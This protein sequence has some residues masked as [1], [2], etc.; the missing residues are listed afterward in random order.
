MFALHQGLNVWSPTDYSGFS[1]SFY[2][3]PRLAK[4]VKLSSQEHWLLAALLW[5]WLQVSGF[6]VYFCNSRNL[7]SHQEYIIQRH[8]VI[9][10]PEEEVNDKLC[11][12]VAVLLWGSLPSAEQQIIHLEF[13]SHFCYFWEFITNGKYNI[14]WGNMLQS[15]KA[16]FQFFVLVNVILIEAIVR[17]GPCT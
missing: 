11:G 9:K 2:L 10:I 16:R 6:S 4:E 13:P 15:S 3:S 1:S 12:R 8:I 7:P 5:R 14:I 17:V